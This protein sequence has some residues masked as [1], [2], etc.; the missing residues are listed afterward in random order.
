MNQIKTEMGY[1]QRKINQLED[2]SLE[3]YLIFHGI[4]ESLPDDEE[5]RTE[6]IYRA[7]SDTISRETPEER[8]QLAREVEIIKT[9]RLGKPDPSR[10]RA[11]SVELSNKYDVEQIYANRFSME[12]GVFIDREFSRETEKDRRLLRPI[13]KVA[14]NL[15]EYKKKCRLEGNQLVLDGKQYH[16][17]NLHQLPKKLE[18]MKV[19]T[20]TTENSIGFFVELCPLSNFHRSPFLYNEV[21]YS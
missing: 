8:L 9:R 7:I 18:P 4:S 15:P 19:A 3:R 1:F 11:I 12:E 17:E 10:I 5:A 14:K 16:K 13:L 21:N 6:K 2:R 20:K